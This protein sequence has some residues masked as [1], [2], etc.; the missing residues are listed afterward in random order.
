MHKNWV[1]FD[2]GQKQLLKIWEDV[3]RPGVHYIYSMVRITDTNIDSFLP[4][5]EIQQFI[6]ALRECNIL[7]EGIYRD[8]YRY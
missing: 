7:N 8:V 3:L 2:K 1:D 5:G 4:R 6:I